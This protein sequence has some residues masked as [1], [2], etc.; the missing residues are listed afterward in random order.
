MT[1]SIFGI[2]RDNWRKVAALYFSLPPHSVLITALPPIPSLLFPLW[3]P[4]LV[5]P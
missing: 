3:G 1:I 4:D 2:H 5:D